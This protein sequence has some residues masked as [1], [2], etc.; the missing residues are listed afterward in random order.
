MKLLY[1]KL[2]IR[3][4]EQLTCEWCSCYH[5]DSRIHSRQ[6]K[7]TSFFRALNMLFFICKIS[8]FAWDKS[9]GEIK[10]I[11]TESRVSFS[12]P[13][14]DFPFHQNFLHTK[15][16]I[17]QALTS[18]L[19]SNELAFYW[20]FKSWSFNTNFWISTCCF[21]VANTIRSKKKRYRKNS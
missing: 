15:A 21:E 8:N 12:R 17:Q 9:P 3:F 13:F 7:P 1:N 2:I 19:I 6:V 16:Y 5:F 11:Q 10:L 14:R 4:S 18:C 20:I